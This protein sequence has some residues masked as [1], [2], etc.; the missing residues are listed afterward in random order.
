MA[1]GRHRTGPGRCPTGSRTGRR[2]PRVTI[3][4]GAAHPPLLRCGY[5]CGYC[6][7][8]VSGADHSVTPG[9]LRSWSVQTCR[10]VQ[11]T[12]PALSTSKA[13]NRPTVLRSNCRFPVA[14]LGAEPQWSATQGLTT[15]IPPRGGRATLLHAPCPGRSD[16]ASGMSCG[17][18]PAWRRSLHGGSVDDSVDRWTHPSAQPRGGPARDSVTAGTSRP[19]PRHRTTR[20]PA[21]PG[22]LT[23]PART[24]ATVTGVAIL[25]ITVAVTGAVFGGN[26]LRPHLGAAET[27][28][29]TTTAP[30]P[31]PAGSTG[32]TTRQPASAESSVTGAAPVP[33]SLAIVS[34]THADPPPAPT[35]V[36][37]RTS[38]Q[39]TQSTRAHPTPS[40]PP[41]PT[42]TPRRPG[43]PTPSPSPSGSPTSAVSPSPSPSGMPS[44]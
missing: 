10:T 19:G 2:P 6:G 22:V 34:P 28:G 20:P 38:P 43:R 42:T 9:S 4:R 14:T 36:A 25:M 15:R 18:I 16:C 21:T 39:P 29:P 23:G 24:A 33:S 8:V 17:T 31:V 40:P 44:P 32:S 13:A 27:T 26:P 12:A 41:R 3:S 30:L 7:A 5:W 37:T 11:T 35:G 1:A